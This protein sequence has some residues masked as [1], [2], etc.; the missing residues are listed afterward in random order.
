MNGS[1]LATAVADRLRCHYW[2]GRCSRRQHAGRRW[3]VGPAWGWSNRPSGSALLAGFG[4]LVSVVGWR[5]PCCGDRGRQNLLGLLHL[6]PEDAP[7]GPLPEALLVDPPS[8]VAPGVQR[9]DARAREGSVNM[10]LHSGDPHRL[11]HRRALKTENPRGG[12]RRDRGRG[13]TAS[14]PATTA[15]T[16]AATTIGG[17]EARRGGAPVPDRNSR[18]LRS[19]WSVA[20]VSGRGGAERHL[21]S[22]LGVRQR[23]HPGPWRPERVGRGHGVHREPRRTHLENARQIVPRSPSAVPLGAVPR[24]PHHARHVLVSGR[25]SRHPCAQLVDFLDIRRVWER[26]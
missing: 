19:R 7:A 9:G 14:A 11:T 20:T 26:A 2:A 16:A 13:P 18:A 3:L 21:E 1:P 17:T 15:A 5:G 23:P 25:L 4:D 6:L 12:R 22:G 8:R 10:L 24:R